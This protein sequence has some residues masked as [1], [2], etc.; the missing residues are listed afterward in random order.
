VFLALGAAKTGTDLSQPYHVYDVAPTLLAVRGFPASADMPGRVL[1]VFGPEAAAGET[2][3]VEKRALTTYGYRLSAASGGLGDA[4]TDE[5][6]MR[7]LKTLGY[8]Q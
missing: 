4:K 7:L 1:P 5:E 3:A 6:M 2:G 8:I